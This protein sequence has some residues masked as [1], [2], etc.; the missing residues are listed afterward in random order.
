[1]KLSSV[2]KRRVSLEITEELTRAYARLNRWTM[3]DPH[4]E[5]G[6]VC[7]QRGPDKGQ[8][9]LAFGHA[10]PVH[11][12]HCFRADYGVRTSDSAEIYS[13]WQDCDPDLDVD[14]GL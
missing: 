6:V 11:I 10:S 5:A 8:C 14:D 9:T 13:A 1:M 12:A 7:G 4:F 2:A 3:T